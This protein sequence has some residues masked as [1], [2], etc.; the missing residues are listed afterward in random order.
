MKFKSPLSKFHSLHAWGYHVVIPDDVVQHFKEK[1]V[2]RLLAIF[3]GDIEYQC[4]LQSNGDGTY[5][6]NINKDVRKQL[7]LTI[8]EEIDIVLTEDQSKYGMPM[9]EEFAELLK[10]DDEADV[11]FHQLTPGKQRSLLYMIGKPKSS[12]KRLEKAVVICD[13]LKATMGKVDFRGLTEFIKKYNQENKG[14]DF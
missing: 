4:A 10:I 14:L 2:K 9:P 12:N 7:A 6:I 8:G 11:L 5:F 1:K 3:N 13:Y